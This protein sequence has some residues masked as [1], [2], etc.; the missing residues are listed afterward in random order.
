MSVWAFLAV[1]FAGL[2]ALAVWKGWRRV[3]FIAKPAVIV[4]LFIWLAGS[5]GLQ[6]QALWFGL[7]L[8]FSVVGDV[9]LLFP[10]ERMFIGGLAS[11]QLTQVCYLFGFS[12]Q[13]LDLT[14]WSLV[15][16]FLILLNA[17]RLLRRIAGTMR[18]AGQNRMIYPVILYGLTISLMLY[19]AMSTISDPDWGTGAAILTSLGAFLFWISDLM[20]AWNKFVTPLKSGRL[21][22]LVTYQLG[23]I[24][25][26]AGVIR[27]FG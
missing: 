27:H 1:I 13:L 24:L 10:G 5:T 21:P 3:E 17:A 7:G 20:I 19:A 18:A 25:L 15:L 4:F 22:I 16:L 26:I 8:V 6:G 12:A 23:Q 2:E 9:L 11:F 14:A